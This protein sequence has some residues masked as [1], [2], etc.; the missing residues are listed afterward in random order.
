MT[1]TTTV[2]TTT[3]SRK[4][5]NRSIGNCP[6]KT[7]DTDYKSLSSKEKKLRRQKNAELKAEYWGNNKGI[8]HTYALA[9]VK[10]ALNKSINDNYEKMYGDKD[11]KAQMQGPALDI[12]KT[13]VQNK[14][15]VKIVKAV[16]KSDD[17]KRKTI[18]EKLLKEYNTFEC[19]NN[20]NNHIGKIVKPNAIKRTLHLHD[21]TKH[22]ARNANPVINEC[23][24]QLIKSVGS[25]LASE[26]YINRKKQVNREMMNKAA[27]AITGYS[28]I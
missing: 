19:T 26:L 21:H 3:T 24:S 14:I 12:F 11:F 5:S 8:G 27:K 4:T 6:K 16:K 18:D 20:K 25:H 1:K 23:L 2:T 10:R 9:P 17:Y 13:M 15:S 28:Y 22:L 7:Y